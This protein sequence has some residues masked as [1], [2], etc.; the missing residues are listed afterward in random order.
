MKSKTNHRFLFICLSNA[1]SFCA[2]NRNTESGSTW[3]IC[4][5]RYSYLTKAKSEDWGQECPSGNW[6]KKS[7][8]TELLIKFLNCN[9]YE[10]NKEI[11]M[12]RMKLWLKSRWVKSRIHKA[13]YP[14]NPE[15]Q[16]GKKKNQDSRCELQNQ[17]ELAI[18]GNLRS[19]RQSLVFLLRA[20]KIVILPIKP[21]CGYP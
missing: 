20:S 13:E 6:E 16:T 9:G 10:K 1:N 21:R 11:L 15:E 5:S 2:L 19:H 12:I 14:E 17:R 18:D 7:R 8:D 4:Y 3:N